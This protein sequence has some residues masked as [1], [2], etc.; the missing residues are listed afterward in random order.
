MQSFRILLKGQS[1][2][3]YT[4]AEIESRLAEGQITLETLAQASDESQS[5]WQSVDQ[6]F[7]KRKIVASPPLIPTVQEV[8]VLPLPLPVTAARKGWGLIEKLALACTI[9][10][11][12][13]MGNF[14]S[15]VEWIKAT[16]GKDVWTGIIYILDV[17]NENPELE[18]RLWTLII[19]GPGA[20]LFGLIS[21]ALC[22]VSA[23]RRWPKIWFAVI[24]SIINYLLLNAMP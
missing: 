14:I 18:N 12:L 23:W 7:S 2:G 20:I 1:H 11:W 6:L 22:G 10:G 19:S 24:L 21:M 3:P 8:R 15:T 9:I 4:I 13:L 16:Y 5:P 17:V